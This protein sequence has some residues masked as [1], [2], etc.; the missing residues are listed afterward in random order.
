MKALTLADVHDWLTYDAMTGLLHWKKSPR[1]G[2]A[3]GTVAG[4]KNKRGY[5]AV[6]ICGQKLY[7]H[8]LAWL[9]SHGAWPESGVDHINGNKED[10]RIANLRVIPQALNVQ[11]KRN[12]SSRNST[13]LLGVSRARGNR[14]AAFIGVGKRNQYLGQFA[15]AQEAQEAYLAAKRQLHPACTI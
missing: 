10:N 15:T 9:L 3:S 11:N 8:R 7:A 5:L 6:N 14:F 4:S 2:I 1:Y 13:G 12:A